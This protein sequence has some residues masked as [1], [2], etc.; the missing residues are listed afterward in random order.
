[1]GYEKAAYCQTQYSLCRS[2]RIISVQ[3]WGLRRYDRLTFN[4]LKNSVMISG[5]KVIQTRNIIIAAFL[6]K[7]LVKGKYDFVLPF[8]FYFMQFRG[9]CVHSPVLFSLL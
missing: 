2:N 7:A 6:N 8:T 3:V 1:M 4:G 5:A 9:G